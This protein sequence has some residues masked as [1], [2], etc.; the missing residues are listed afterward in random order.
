[1][2]FQALGTP[3]K[4][5]ISQNSNFAYKEAYN[6]IFLCFKKKMEQTKSKKFLFIW[7]FLWTWTLIIYIL[8]MAFS[9]I[10]YIL[11]TYIII[12]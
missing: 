12:I 8:N 6:F 4:M 3:A 7:I 5:Y 1:M 11:K 10:G 9:F 2:P